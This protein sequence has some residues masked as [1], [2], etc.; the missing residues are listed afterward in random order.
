MVK[1]AYMDKR[2]FQMRLQNPQDYSRYSRHFVDSLD[3]THDGIIAFS[4]SEMETD[5]IFG[6]VMKLCQPWCLRNNKK[7]YVM[8]PSQLHYCKYP[9]FGY[10]HV[11][12]VEWHG[13]DMML[14]DLRETY[15]ESKN[16]LIRTLEIGGIPYPNKLFVCYNNREDTHRTM[17][18]DQLEAHDLL[19]KGIVTYKRCRPDLVDEADFE[20][21]SKP[22]WTPE[23]F[24]R[25]YFKGLIDIVT[26]SRY[27]PGEHYLSEKT[28]KPIV[29]LKPFLVLSAQGYHTW[30]ERK[31]IKKYNIFDYSFD[32]EPKLEDRVEGIIQNL[33]RLDALYKTPEDYAN[34]LKELEPDMQHNLDAY[35]NNIKNG[36]FLLNP[37]LDYLKQYHFPIPNELLA[38]DIR[39]DVQ[40]YYEFLHTVIV[41]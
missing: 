37:I 39:H 11:E 26:E 36:Q 1:Y 25:S 29:G 31:G 22:E 3:S 34:V 18:V 9:N 24:P 28:F 32:N 33:K 38:K 8:S 35:T 4:G 7:I 6:E 5:T 20:L 14:Y 23:A 30:L 16:Q 17:L 15:R 13:Y 41:R 12:H 19:E 10:P 21:N 40:M 27:L 2:H